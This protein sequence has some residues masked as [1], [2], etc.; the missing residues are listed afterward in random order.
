[1]ERF[2]QEVQAQGKYFTNGLPGVIIPKPSA[3]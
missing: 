2:R 1:M 3:S